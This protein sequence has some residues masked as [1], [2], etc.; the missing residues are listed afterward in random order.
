MLAAPVTSAVCRVARKVRTIQFFISMDTRESIPNV[1]NG[2]CGGIS[3][4]DRSRNTASLTTM[5]PVICPIASSTV[6]AFFN[7][8]SILISPLDSAAAAILSS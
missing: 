6:A 2:S 5:V 4:A 8:A 7:A 3:D 1:A